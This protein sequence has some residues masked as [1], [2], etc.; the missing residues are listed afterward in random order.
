MANEIIQGDKQKKSLFFVVTKTALE[1]GW[2][3]LTGDRP[4]EQTFRDLLES[5]P[6]FANKED[7]AKEEGT[8]NNIADLQGLVIAANDEQVVSD[9][10]AKSESKTWA[11]QPTQVTRVTGGAEES[12]GSTSGSGLTPYSGKVINVDKTGETKRRVYSIESNQG[13]LS[14]VGS[15]Y[16]KVVSVSADSTT[17]LEQIEQNR[18]N[19]E[20]LDQEVNDPSSG[21]SQQV[22]TAQSTADNAQTSANAAQSTADTA[23]SKADAA[24]STADS[25]ESTANA[26]S[27]DISDLLTAF[28]SASATIVDSDMPTIA[29]SDRN[30]FRLNTCY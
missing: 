6:F 22:S 12:I 9:T 18:Q 26:N 2:N 20:T 30:N 13:F 11:V 14:W 23:N 15:L 17:A 29:N 24:Q 4:S 28:Y 1:R 8:A 7:R 27:N 3:F 25:A 16:D 21:L 19:I 5:I 10:T